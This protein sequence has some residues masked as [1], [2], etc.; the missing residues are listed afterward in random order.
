MMKK[1][2]LAANSIYVST[3]H[4]KEIVDQY[5]DNLSGVFEKISPVYPHFPEEDKISFVAK[6]VV[7]LDKSGFP[8]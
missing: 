6:I 2:M 4:T 5:I 8:K 1:K 7:V 3:E